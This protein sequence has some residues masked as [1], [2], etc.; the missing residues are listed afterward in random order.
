MKK[1]TSIGLIAL[2]LVL[3]GAGCLSSSSSTS[4]TGGVW[5]TQ[6]S[7]QN[8][9]QLASLPQASGVGSI[10]GVNVT[11]IEIDPSDSTVYY[12]GTD[13]NGVFVSYDVG[14]TWE[15]PDSDALHAGT[16]ID[17]EVSPEDV[18]TIYFAFSNTVLKTTD[19]MR[20]VDDIYDVDQS[21]EYV[22]SFDIDWY[23]PDNLWLGNEQGAVVKSADAGATWATI[24]RIS[25]DITDIE[26][27]KADSRIILVG[28]DRRGLYRSIDSGLS[29]TEF[30][31]DLRKE[32]KDSDKVY[33]FT[34]TEDG[35]SL[36]MN[37]EYG[38]LTS[39]DMGAT[40]EGLNLLTEEGEAKIW[41]VSFAP[42]NASDIYYTTSNTFYSTSSGGQSWVTEDLA[43]S[44]TPYVV[45]V[46]PDDMDRVWV[47]FRALDN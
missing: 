5:Q 11:V 14:T 44:R 1:Y 3:V 4:S 22:T 28:T 18:C 17:I 33:N 25:D 27:S 43:S 19:C 10:A 30:E 2:S 36:I 45:R 23:S 12:L 38:L 20:S 16:L 39:V 21:D 13:G 8:W 15:R 31:D 9:T 29:W 6:D 35:T 47:G 26:V 42:H 34:Q 24:Y 32:F 41:D 46:N 40:W 37:T 7:G